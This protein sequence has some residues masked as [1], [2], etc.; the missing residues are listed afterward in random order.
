MCTDAGGVDSAAAGTAA[1]QKQQ[2][3]LQ[4]QQWCPAQLQ[5]AA[6]DACSAS[7]QWWALSG[8]V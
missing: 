7:L 3:K 8:C 4:V 6:Y 5:V 2:L 1:E